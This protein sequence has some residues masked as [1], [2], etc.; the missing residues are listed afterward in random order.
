[1]SKN[2]SK[3]AN[4]NEV[5]KATIV[6]LV[7]KKGDVSFTAQVGKNIIKIPYSN[8]DPNF[9]PEESHI[10]A[11]VIANYI[12][13]EVEVRLEK[14]GNG[15]IV[16]NM[17]PFLEE[18]TK[19]TIENLRKGPAEAKFTKFTNFGAFM[20]ID[21]VSVIMRNKDFSDDF[22]QIKNHHDIGDILK[23]KIN[24]INGQ[25]RIYVEPVQK[26][27]APEFEIGD[28]NVGDIR[29]GKLV[30]IK[31]LGCFVNIKSG[32]DGIT[33]LPN[34]PNV[35]FNVGDMVVYQI[36]KIDEEEKKVKLQVLRKI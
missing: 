15:E 22:L 13:K 6:D 7:N 27:Q 2:L 9:N 24:D 33:S 31:P 32:L 1:M 35:V 14:K 26:M 21:G 4:S 20:D 18:K 12:M 23:V 5:V 8:F 25:N 16:G 29:V 19:S 28:I 17:I 11:V 3:L 34:I 10:P 30:Q 36:K